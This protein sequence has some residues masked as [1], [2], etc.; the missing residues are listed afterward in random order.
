M[1]GLTEDSTNA[2]DV[3]VIIPAHDCRPYLDRSLTSALV[4][5]VHK[6]IVV[7]DDGSTDGSAELLELYA[8]YHRGTVKVIRQE[9]SGGAGRPRNVGLDHATGRYVFFCDADDYLG[10]EALERMVAMADR[11][12]SDIV[13]GKVVGH[14]RRAPASMFRQNAERVSLAD[15]AVYN[16]L[17]CWKLFRRQMLVEHGIRFGEDRLV[18]EDLLFTVHAYCHAEVIS[19]VADYDCYHLTARPDGTSIMQRPDSRDPIAWLHMIRDPIQ[20]MAAH[21]PPGP[22]RDHLLRR[23]FRLDAFAQLGEAFLAADEVR[24]KDI[25]QEVAALCDEWLTPG[26][27][28]L[29]NPADR[30]RLAALGDVERLVRLAGIEAATVHRRLTDLR[31]EGERL[32]VSGVAGLEGLAEYDGVALLLRSRQDPGRE[33]VVPAELDGPEFTARIDVGELSSGVWDLLV[34]IELEGV[35]RQG[36]LGAERDRELP[37]PSPRLVGESVALP[38]FTRSGGN[39]SID[40]GGHVLSVPGSAR[41]TS[42]RWA[43]G[44]RLVLDGHVTVTGAAPAE[45]AVR[46]LVW[47]ERNTGDERID[48]VVGLPGGAFEAKPS[49]GRLVPGTWDAYLELELGGP[50]ARFRIETTSTQLFA[51]PRRWWQGAVLRSVRPY[52]TAGKGRLSTVVKTLTPKAIISRLFQ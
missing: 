7:V 5:R 11:N 25:A 51:G 3:S 33:L 50:P 43:F 9:H 46:R 6:E 40:I 14:G 22:L 20:L 39:L 28:E 10:D 41:L 1:S 23:H 15:S 31:W 47:R 45:N 44:H 2:V 4:Q 19:V 17:S 52:A 49:V 26:V 16:S 24:R 48:R 32:L 27:V 8:T 34:T 30:Q 36:R 12:G 42:A 13:L 38:Y 18:G 21:V 35:H 29:L 37:C